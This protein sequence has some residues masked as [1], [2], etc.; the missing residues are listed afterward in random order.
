M[1]DLTIKAMASHVLLT[2]DNSSDS[3]D[4]NNVTKDV[5]SFNSLISDL[6]IEVLSSDNFK[7]Y[8]LIICQ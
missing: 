3:F 8:T 2:P 6:G 5:S 4:Q 1:V 7:A